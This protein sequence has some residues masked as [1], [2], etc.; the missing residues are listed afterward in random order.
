MR[1]IRCV[2]SPPLSPSPA[3]RARGIW[4][5]EAELPQTAEADASALQK[6][7]RAAP[8]S[9]RAG[10]GLGM[11]AQKKFG[12]LAHAGTASNPTNAP[13]C[14]AAPRMRGDYTPVGYNPAP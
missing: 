5:A 7:W 10:E 6:R 4:S 2:P 13:K 1:A 12:T 3:E 14:R 8:L 9:R 11:R